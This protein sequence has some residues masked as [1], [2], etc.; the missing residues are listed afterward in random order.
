MLD[1]Q[2]E[3]RNELLVYLNRLSD[4][5]FVVARYENWLNQTDDV[6]WL[7]IKRK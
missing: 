3:V 5:L 4:L 6:P 7:G 1:S 2:T